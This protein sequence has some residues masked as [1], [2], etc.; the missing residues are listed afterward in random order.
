MK[1][2]THLILPDLKEMLPEMDREAIESA[3]EDFHPADVADILENIEDADAVK[4]FEALPLRRRVEAF[5]HLEEPGQMHLLERVGRDK[6][7]KVIEEMSSDDRVDLLQALPQGTVDSILPLLAQAERNDIKKLLAYEE[8]TAGAAMTTEYA[9][10]RAEMNVADALAHLR[11]IA[12]ERET[13]YEIYVID[14]ERHL[15]GRLGLRRL[16]LSKPDQVVSDLMSPPPFTVHVGDDQEDVARAFEKYDV[17]AIPVLDAD[18]KLVGIVTHDDVIDIIEEEATEDVQRLGGVAPLEVPYLE[19]PFLALWRKRVG[20]LSALFLG[21]IFT[22][23]AL[24]HYDSV[25]QA[26]V[27]LTIFLPLIISSGGNSGS[28]SASLVTRGLALGEV[29]VAEWWRVV[30]RELFVGLL[31]GVALVPFGV[32]RSWMVGAPH[33]FSIAVSFTL[34]CVVTAG[35]IVGAVLPLLTKRLGFDPA[36]SS[37]PFVASLV[38]VFGIV[39]YVNI[40]KYLGAASAHPPAIVHWLV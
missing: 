1:D 40:V 29:N 33:A 21:E 16:V 17:L 34:I 26:T 3:F 37:T 24:K 9:S 19:E 35:S 10:L 11:K 25:I 12:P 31:L 13:I 30:R 36:V 27:W 20:W 6:M 23:S 22:T 2:L 4:V 5:E 18:D 32:L 15:Q 14:G 7:I 8:G 28:Q 39:I 38:D